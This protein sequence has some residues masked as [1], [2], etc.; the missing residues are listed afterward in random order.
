[1]I[2]LL[3][4]YD[5]RGQKNTLLTIVR[6]G[7]EWMPKLMIHSLHKTFSDGTIAVRNLTLKA[8]ETQITVLAGPAGSGKSSVF[9]L[10]MGMDH[11][12]QGDVTLNDEPILYRQGQGCST[13]MISE[14]Y[15]LYPHMTVAQ[16][17]AFG[18]KIEHIDKQDIQKRI[19][20]IA[21]LLEIEDILEDKAEDLNQAQKFWVVLGRAACRQPSVYLL[22]DPLRWLNPD[23]QL[24]ICRQLTMVQKKLGS[25]FLFATRDCRQAEALEGHVM[26]L[27][28]GSIVQ[29]GTAQDIIQNPHTMFVASFFSSPPLNLVDILP[30]VIDGNLYFLID[31][32]GHS[33]GNYA[34]S[35]RA[36]GYFPKEEVKEGRELTVGIRPDGIRM[37]REALNQY[38]DCVMEATVEEIER[39]PWHCL[40]LLDLDGHKLVMKPTISCDGLEEGDVIPV[41]F[42]PD[43]MLLFDKLSGKTIL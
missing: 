2:Y 6:K 21:A 7:D 42:L 30:H 10:V 43:R 32:K 23:D 1:M 39:T 13:I 40:V 29:S 34:V 15:V 31:H 4:R 25:I 24:S 33:P 28:D 14:H 3:Y 19:A 11:P 38:P 36:E 5:S 17:M 22:D 27:R 41:A 8:D 37:D 20:K 18:L 16:N 35:I 26:V 12:D 9:R